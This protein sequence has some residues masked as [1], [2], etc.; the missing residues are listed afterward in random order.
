LEYRIS[1]KRF[2]SL[3][4]LNLRQLVG[5]LVRGI[6]PSQGRCVTQTQIK[7]G[8]TSMP[9]VELLK[10]RSTISDAAQTERSNDICDSN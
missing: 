4:F 3:Q 9:L 1:V 7:H 5:L 10:Q 6:S 8:Q 2:V